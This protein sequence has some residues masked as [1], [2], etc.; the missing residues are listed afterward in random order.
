MGVEYLLVILVN[1]IGETVCRQRGLAENAM[2]NTLEIQRTGQG[3]VEPYS[4]QGS[5]AIITYKCTAN[6]KSGARGGGRRGLFGFIKALYGPFTAALL[7]RG[8]RFCPSGCDVMVQFAVNLE[9]IILPALAPGRG[10]PC[11][12]RFNS[13]FRSSSAG[14]LC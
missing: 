13:K 6:E 8:H 11:S 9:T 2:P 1:R 14:Q 10:C 4:L 7:I 5:E 3:H 12:A